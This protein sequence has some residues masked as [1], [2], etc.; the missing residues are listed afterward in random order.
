MNRAEFADFLRERPRVGD[1]AMGTALYHAGVA[2]RRCF[3]DLNRSDPDRVRAVHAAHLAAGAEVLTTNTFGANRFQ[4]AKHGLAGEAAA[5]NRA[6]VRVARSAAAGG[7]AVFGSVGPT[8]EILAS[9]D[10]PRAAEV[11]AAFVEQIEALAEA[12]ADALLIETFTTLAEARLA[13]AAAREVAPDLGVAVLTTFSEQLETALG[14]APDRV[15]AELDRA[16]ADAVGANCGVGPESAYAAL[17]RMRRGTDLPLIAQ[18]NAGIPARK[19][20]RFFY[21]SSPDYSGHYAKRYLRLGVRVIGGCCGTGPA[22]LA[23]IAGVIRAEAARTGE[24]RPSPAPR[25]PGKAPIPGG[26]K[27]PRPAPEELPPTPLPERSALARALVE[28]RF[29]VSVEMDPPRGAD[30]GKLLGTAGELA[31]AGVR[32]VNVADGPRATARMSAIAFAALLERGGKVETIL[33]YQCR[34]RNLIGIQ[35]DLLGAH[36]LGIR[37]LLAVTGDPPKL[38]D[39]PHATPVF[40]TDSVGLV[41]ILQGLNRGLDLAGNPVG[42]ALPFHIGVGA[43]PAAADF[44]G[45]IAKF[46]RKRDAGAEYCLTQPVYEPALLERF[47]EAISPRRIPVLVGVLPLVSSRNAEFLHNEV[48]GMTVPQAVRER[49]AAASGRAEARSVGVSVARE[50]VEAA[51]GLAEGVYLMPPFHRFDLAVRSLE[52]LLRD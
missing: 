37:N 19:D 6:G 3:D 24:T 44:E 13:L 42:A 38:G 50:M 7:E 25:A 10:D 20:G 5:I 4:L 9:S 46:E 33:H 21:P 15:G 43:N 35:A 30:A 8:G 52:G 22:H 48:P 41:R 16:G 14:T 28:G 36:A 47:L 40:D 11:R 1:G 26:A 31:E 18:P 2:A 27:P 29:A 17:E 51:Q 23:A 32:F 45:E 49:L 34:D 12:G 39:Y